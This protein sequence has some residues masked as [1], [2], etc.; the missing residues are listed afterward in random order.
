MFKHRLLFISKYFFGLKAYL[1]NM[2][3]CCNV[4]LNTLLTLIPFHINMIDITY[5]KTKLWIGKKK[6]M[7][8]YHWIR[9]SFYIHKRIPWIKGKIIMGTYHNVTITSQ[10]WSILLAQIRPW[11]RRGKIHG[12]LP[13]HDCWT[14]IMID[15]VNAYTK[16]KHE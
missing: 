4:Y 10:W 8:T 11:T 7:H 3:I 1:F 12:H 2:V 13:L 6:I 15:F 16:G 9:P 14:I 5:T